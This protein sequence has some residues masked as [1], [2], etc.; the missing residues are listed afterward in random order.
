MIE[1][2]EKEVRVRR[3]YEYVLLS[4]DKR[5]WD[6]RY[7]TQVL[8]S[9]FLKNV[10]TRTNRPE[11]AA[12]AF[13][14]T[15]FFDEPESFPFEIGDC[16]HYSGRP[17]RILGIESS[18]FTIRVNYAHET[19]RV[20]KSQVRVAECFV[21][22]ARVPACRTTQRK[23][24]QFPIFEYHVFEDST[25][26][27]DG[28]RRF[29]VKS[30]FRPF[31]INGADLVY[32]YDFTDA[33]WRWRSGHMHVHTSTRVAI[34]ETGAP[35]DLANPQDTPAADPQHVQK[36][37][38][39]TPH[40]FVV[41]TETVP[42]ELD[43]GAEMR[44][45][46]LRAR[47]QFEKFRDS[48]RI[49]C[50]SAKETF[51]AMCFT[52]Y[53]TLCLLWNA[54]HTPQ[55][56]MEAAESLENLVTVLVTQWNGR[57]RFTESFLHPAMGGVVGFVDQLHLVDPPVDFQDDFEVVVATSG[58][59][60]D[61]YTSYHGRRGLRP[62]QLQRVKR[63][64]HWLRTSKSTRADVLERQSVALWSYDQLTHLLRDRGV[65]FAPKHM[66]TLAHVFRTTPTGRVNN[67]VL[68][69]LRRI[70]GMEKPFFPFEQARV[71]RG[72]HKGLPF[73]VFRLCAL[74]D[75]NGDDTD[76]FWLNQTDGT[77]SSLSKRRFKRL[78]R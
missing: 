45:R 71:Y 25:Q 46:V 67:V 40:E 31:R 74:Q 76:V 9:S 59:T 50:D 11:R 4:V 38:V 68:G 8:L 54:A 44:R 24:E 35:S 49:H 55:R 28:G 72:I 62:P 12:R 22:F 21:R 32:A 61:A 73:F 37:V 42:N 10:T 26:D 48:L 53:F 29:I 47:A 34:E 65:R 5:S 41:C 20:A 56:S 23:V 2:S 33:F 69:L 16:V 1:S 7:P 27:V 58:R 70:Q 17:A 36:E 60:W 19:L 13:A 78:I 52:P 15:C 6:Q 39:Y 18:Q 14:K 3:F 63:L 75:D 30:L 77:W 64:A 51:F 43:V 66:W 57:R